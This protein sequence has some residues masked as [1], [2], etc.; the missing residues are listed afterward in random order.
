MPVL[1][2]RIEILFSNHPKNEK[3]SWLKEGQ[4][5]CTSGYGG[6]GVRK[7]VSKEGWSF[8][9][10]VFHHGSHHSGLS[11]KWSFIRAIF[12]ESDFSSCP[13]S[14]R[15]YILCLSSRWSFTKVVFHQGNCSPR[16]S[17]IMVVFHQGGLLPKWSFIK[18]VSPD[19][20]LCG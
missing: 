9:M 12:H 2:G 5:V 20:T 13:L 10:V 4:E 1:F 6:K 18:V 19:I 11:P 14:P 7:V 15:W 17:F 3:K 16:L 8:I